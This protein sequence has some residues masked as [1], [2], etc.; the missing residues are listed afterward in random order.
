[1]NRNERKLALQKEINDRSQSLKET[2]EGYKTIGKDALLIG[3]IIVLGYTL[4]RVFSDDD[5][6]EENTNTD[7]KPSLL[8]S[9]LR[10][11][12][13]SLVLALAKDK[14]EDFLSQMNKD[15]E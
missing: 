1:M 10:A 15:D 8:S 9:T 4:F 7:N 14:L 2:A 5:N 13:S 12:A 6:E 3:G 11:T